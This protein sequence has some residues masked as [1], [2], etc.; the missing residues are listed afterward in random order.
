MDA[1]LKYPNPIGI[2]AGRP[3]THK[4][5]S[6]KSASLKENLLMTFY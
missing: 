4:Q 3:K 1:L 6:L 5:P 2:G